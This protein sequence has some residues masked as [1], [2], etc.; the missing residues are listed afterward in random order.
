MAGG[1][2]D[3]DGAVRVGGTAG[4]GVVGEAILSAELAIDAIEDGAE[5]LGHVGV[6]HGATGGVGHGFEGMLAAG[7]AA[8]L[9]FHRADDN[10]VK[11]RVGAHGFFAGGVEVVSTGGFTSIG[12]EDNDPAPVF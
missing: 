2:L 9:I 6:E 10:G 8:A 11:K 7:V 4:A 5:F 12:D 3:F 1:D